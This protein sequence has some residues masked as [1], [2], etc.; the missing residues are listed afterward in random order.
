MEPFEN[1]K[2]R[3]H[4]EPDLAGRITEELIRLKTI[5]ISALRLCR[6]LESTAMGFLQMNQEIE[7]RFIELKNLLEKGVN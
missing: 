3:L 5:A 4:N 7:K 6:E 2:I 1:L